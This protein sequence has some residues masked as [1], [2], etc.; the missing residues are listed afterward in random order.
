M[1]KKILVIDDDDKILKIFKIYLENK[2]YL[3][4][5]VDSGIKALK[6]LEK[7]KPDLIF[8]D[9]LM[10]EMD[11]YEVCLRLQDKEIFARIPVIFISGLDDT[12]D[13]A[14]AFSCGG[15]DYIVKPINKEEM[16]DKVQKHLKNAT[17]WQDG[18]KKLSQLDSMGSLKQFKQF[19]EFLGDKLKL[20]IEQK[21]VLSEVKYT[22]IDSLS[23]PLD[24]S[25]TQLAQYM[26][27]FLKIEYIP[28]LDPEI[29][30]L[31]V[32]PTS[33]CRKHRVIAI[34][35]HLLNKAFVINN[36]F[37][38]ELMDFLRRMT[39]YKI[40][41][42]EPENIDSIFKDRFEKEGSNKAVINIVSQKISKT[43]I[44]EHPVKYITNHILYKAILQRASDIHIEPKELGTSIRFRIDGDMQPAFFLKGKTGVKLI[45]RFKVLANLDIAERRKPQDG[46]FEIIMNNKNF[47]LRVTT[48]NTAYGE[49][50]IL[51][52]LEPR[53]KPKSLELLGM[54]PEQ[55]KIMR[56]FANQSKGLVLL[57]G[58]TG[59]GKTTTIYSFLNQID[60]K[61][62]SLI[63]VEDPIEYTI[64]DANQ[65]QVNE[66]IGINF[67][68]LLKSAVRQDP[69]IL[70]L[71]EIRDRYSA[72][73][74]MEA[75]STGHLTVTS[76]H[77]ANATTAVFRLETLDIAHSTMADSILVITAQKL[78]K[79]LC[80]HCKKVSP[81]SK[82]EIRLLSMYTTDIP[83][84]VAHPVGC[85]KCNNAGYYGREAIYEILEFDSAVSEMVRSS[86]PISQIRSFIRQRGNYLIG[87]HALE[88]L[89]ALKFSVK[90]VCETV[91]V[92]ESG[93]KTEDK[94]V[95]QVIPD[96]KSEERKNILLVEDDEDVR[97]FIARFL[98]N[99]GYSVSVAEDGI[100]A[101]LRM[102]KLNFELILSDI[103]MPNLDG[104]KLLEMKNQKGIKTPVVFL[105]S[106]IN[107]EDEAIGFKMGAADYIRKPFDKETLLLRLN[108]VFKRLDNEKRG[109]NV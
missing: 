34:S 22:D 85:P 49:S 19:K 17:R 24:I 41:I 78:L 9:I 31:G 73:V 68:L 80:P 5:S 87:D 94:K 65:Q 53:I 43:E 55:V 81:I 7:L 97:K 60:C 12:Q 2:D 71:G 76:L 6:M 25:S 57:V 27:E 105:T 32:L 107:H 15:V 45:A 79:V 37:D 66:K 88:K 63:S 14:K 70:F 96:K 92:E 103:N 69:D 40:M 106:R 108:R 18:K 84:E 74:A 8:L 28:Y 72:S 100:D 61:K 77:T 50:I 44:E 86:V 101:L 13:K 20:T 62:R 39:D 33:F 95:I 59:S 93:I 16:L 11:G 67:N 54:T 42:T 29:L 98:E 64:P 52:I 3:V 10:P 1:K 91:L 23:V 89:R 75:A 58:P 102:G 26:A 38:W 21:K 30:Q 47:K 36:P 46:S 83:T 4:N 90:Q 51:R 35:E 104:F 109:K 99:S 48:T 56:K 82:E